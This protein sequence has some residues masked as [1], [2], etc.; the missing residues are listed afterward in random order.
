MRPDAHTLVAAYAVH[1]LDEGERTDVVEHLGQCDTCRDD[2]R[3]FRETATSLAAATAEAPPARMRA[4]V[5]A[6]ARTTPQL[7]PL[8]GERPGTADAVAAATAGGVLTEPTGPI[9]PTE[10]TGPIEPPSGGRRAVAADAVTT[11]VPRSRRGADGEPERWAGADRTGT[12]SRTLF[13]LAASMLTVVALGA[14]AFAV[15]QSDRLG[16]SQQQQA[17]V[18]RVLSADDM[19]TLTAVPQLA[20]GVQGDEVVVLASAS[21]DTVLLFPA[22]LPAAPEGSTWQAWTLTGDRATSA[23]TFDVASGEAVALQA[24]VAGAD[25]VA[26]SLEPAGGSES[27][28]T[29]PVLVMPLA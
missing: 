21:E 7:P 26:V 27:P 15:V 10:P 16:D 5:L 12:T 6:R 29:D 24:S 17:A 14:G 28:S 4:A 9:E 11:R 3:S 18:Q 25:A 19:V 20:E 1:A 23:G 2:L 22:G 13:G 8:T